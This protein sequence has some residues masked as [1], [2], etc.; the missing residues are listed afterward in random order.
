[1]VA[2]TLKSLS[3]SYEHFVKT[4]NFT[5]TNVDLKFLELCNKLLQQDWWKQQFSSSAS[6]SSTEQAFV[7]NSFHK[8]KGKS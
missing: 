5:S 6:L 1:M 2:I 3:K 8:D 7:A 4:L